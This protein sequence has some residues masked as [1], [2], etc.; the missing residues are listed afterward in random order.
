[1]RQAENGSMFSLPLK[2]YIFFRFFKYFVLQKDHVLPRQQQ[3]SGKKSAPSLKNHP[4]WK[5]Q[6]GLQDVVNKLPS[7]RHHYQNLMHQTPRQ[8]TRQSLIS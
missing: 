4:S 3:Q 5:P 2:I 8:L 1:M 6:P 7:H